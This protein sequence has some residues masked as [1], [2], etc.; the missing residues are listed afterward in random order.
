[1][2]AQASA[3]AAPSVAVRLRWGLSDSLVLA[4][5][6]LAHVRQIPEKLLDVTVQPLMFV[7]LFAYVF[8]GAI[9][10]PGGGY[11][12]YLL[13][14]ILVQTLTFGIVGPATS[15]ATDL[16]EGIV[17]RFRSLPMSRSA[18]LLGHLISDL[19]A[20]MLALAIMTASGLIVGWRIH[21]DIPHAIA[22]FALLALFAFTMLWLGMLLGLLARTPDAVTGV[23]FIVIFPLTFIANTFVPAGGLP[24]GL[25]QVAEWNPISA[26][27]AA[28]RTL[29]GNPTALPAHAPWPLL[30]PALSALAWCALVL[31]IVVPLTIRRYRV[32]TAG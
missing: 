24:A 16:T 17:D 27:A 19:A 8:S 18:F 14:G 10:V 25:R 29:F 32:R 11:R 28:V 20:S 26:L 9:H 4:R 6:N 2:S 3:T 22:G 15:I 23:A 21:S 12:Q 31:A 7:L 1:M 5:R 13:G 30:H